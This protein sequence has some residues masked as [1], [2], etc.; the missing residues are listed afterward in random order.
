MEHQAKTFFT[1][2]SAVFTP[3]T[4]QATLHL[5]SSHTSVISFTQQTFTHRRSLH[6]EATSFC[7]QKPFHTE[8][9]TQRSFY[10]E[11]P[12]TFAHR[13][14]Y[15]HQAFKQKSFHTKN[16]SATV[17][18]NP[19]YIYVYLRRR[20]YGRPGVPMTSPLPFLR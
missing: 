14:F 5:S 20:S 3:C 4:S 10:T 17:N 2:H 9:F 11:K 13:S 15:T 19:F 7:T 18:R 6:T 16:L 8:A 12:E 1:L